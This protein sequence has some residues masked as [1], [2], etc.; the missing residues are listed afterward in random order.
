MADRLEEMRAI[1]EHLTC[2]NKRR[3]DVDIAIR[4]QG[5]ARKTLLLA[6][7]LEWAV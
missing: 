3:G 1:V 4:P 6:S 7:K 2:V 5:T